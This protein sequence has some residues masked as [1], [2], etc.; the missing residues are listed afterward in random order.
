MKTHPINE[1]VMSDINIYMY[2]IIELELT[3]IIHKHSNNHSCALLFSV[4]TERPKARLSKNTPA[5]VSMTLT[6]SVSS[7]SPSSSGWK[8]FWYRGKKTSE[9]LI[10]RED[11]LLPKGGGG[12]EFYWCRGGS[13]DPVYYTEYSNTVGKGPT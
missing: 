4:N 7:S 3:S 12:G 11:V 5:G 8:Y 6:C 1:S 2:N 9:P 13:G 10:T